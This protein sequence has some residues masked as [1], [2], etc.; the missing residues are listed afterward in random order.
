MSNEIEKISVGTTAQHGVG[1][2]QLARH[3]E[4]SA[5]VL[6]EQAK[7]NVLAR[8]QMARL[9]PRD[10]ETARTRILKDCDRPRFAELAEYS[11]PRWDARKQKTVQITGPTVRLA[12]VCARAWGNIGVEAV[13][14][15]ED[16][17]KRHVRVTA[18]DYETN[19]TYSTDVTVAKV[20]ERRTVRDAGEVVGQRT[21]S[22]GKVVYVVR[23]SEQDLL[24]KHN[25]LVSKARRNV[26]FC[27]VPG[28]IVDEALERAQATVKATDA[29]DPDAERRRI[30]DSFSKHLSVEPAQL[31]EALGV[32]VAQIG[33][34]Q[35]STL[36]KWFAAIRDGETT[37]AQIIEES[38]PK[39]PPP[40][41]AP[42]ND[43]APDAW[44]PSGRVRAAARAVAA[45]KKKDEP[46]PAATPAQTTI[47][48]TDEQRAARIDRGEEG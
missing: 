30:F 22:E 12:E 7:A 31:G 23:A 20:V 8:F 48:K 33:P 41:D 9:E 3:G 39:A 15:Y 11:L 29:K 42:K 17:E 19:A 46:A 27:I 2:S 25:A 45:E 6:A 32:P 34:A 36:R 37:L 38:K 47:V 44:T 1:G 21:N 4:T 40:D 35:I 24:A 13:I 26:I 10:T 14:T 5:M 18:T 28:D 16:E 43:A